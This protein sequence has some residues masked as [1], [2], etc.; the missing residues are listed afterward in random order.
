MNPNDLH[1]I[2]KKKKKFVS[3]ML[4]YTI[5]NTIFPLR[6]QNSH[7]NMGARQCHGLFDK[8]SFSTLS[9]S[10]TNILYLIFLF[11]S[12]LRISNI[13][14]YRHTFTRVLIHRNCE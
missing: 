4:F 7:S 2:T 1:N 12:K 3:L 13:F 6:S 14:C 9:L 11:R 10:T 5:T 8:E